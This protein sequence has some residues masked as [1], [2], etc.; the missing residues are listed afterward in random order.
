MEKG[1]IQNSMRSFFITGGYHRR[2]ADCAG[3]KAKSF[4]TFETA[5]RTAPKEKIQKQENKKA[6]LRALLF[7]CA[8]RANVFS[9]T[10]T[11]PILTWAVERVK[12]KLPFVS[13]RD[14]A[15]II[16]NA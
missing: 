6:E 9:I 3:T 13:A 2:S 7:Q 12:N 8:E 15:P 4:V 1:R 11:C 5:G 16:K 14:S 10:L